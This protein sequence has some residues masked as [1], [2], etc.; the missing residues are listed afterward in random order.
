MQHISEEV[1][2]ALAARIKRAS[3]DEA[4]RLQQ[5]LQDFRAQ[6]LDADPRTLRE[7]GAALECAGPD[8]GDIG[9]LRRHA[10]LFRHLA[11]T[12]PQRP[13]VGCGE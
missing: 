6:G 9:V 2:A 11:A 4:R 1:G 12:K 10:V 8:C 5:T 3:G 7:I 13:C